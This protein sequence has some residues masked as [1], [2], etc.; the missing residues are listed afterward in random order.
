MPL[1]SPAF[2]ASLAATSSV[3]LLIFYH[4]LAGGCRG[5]SLYQSSVIQIDLIG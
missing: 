1:L 3:F 4:G 2:Y 5:S